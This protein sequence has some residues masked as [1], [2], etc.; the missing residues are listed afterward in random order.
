MAVVD[1]D[2]IR[3][4]VWVSLPDL[5]VAQN[6][7]YWEL[8][9]PSADEPTNAEIV[10]AVD[11]KLT[12]MYQ[13]IDDGMVDEA[14]VLDADIDRVE[15][16]TDH[17][18]NKENVGLATL[19]VTGTN[20]ADMA[21]HGVAGVVTMDTPRPQ[22]RARKFFAGLGEDMF[23]DSDLVTN[24]LSWLTALIVEWL[25]DMPVTGN[26]VLVPSVAGQAGASAGIVYPLIAGAVNALAGY[27]RRRKPGVGS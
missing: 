10:T 2:L 20:T 12:N 5:V 26:A 8:S 9:D 21:P 16:E 11:G 27:Q 14:T 25:L 1:G 15:W 3:V 6:V 7:Y 24:M 22:T 19:A 17:W 18:E 23:T 4:N 13:D